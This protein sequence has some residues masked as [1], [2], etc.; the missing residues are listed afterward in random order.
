MNKWA[1]RLRKLRQHPRRGRFILGRLLWRSGLSPFFVSEMPRGFRIRFYPSSISAALW[2]DPGSR[3]EDEDFVW[4]VLRPGDR[5]IDAGANVGQLV[6]A[7]SKRVGPDGDVIAVEAH[8]EI[9]GYLQGNLRLNR[10]SNVEAFNCALGATEG[11]VSMT[12]R[13]SDDQNYV[14]EAGALRVPMHRLD[15]LIPARPTRLLKIDVE[16]SELPVLQGATAV[17]RETELVY[18]ELSTGNCRRFGYEPQDV[19]TLLL[20]AGFVFIRRD[21]EGRPQVSKRAYFSSLPTE[22]LPATGYNLVAVRP[23]VSQEALEMLSARGW[24]RR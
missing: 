11:E 3:T 4:A 24:F 17:L 1:Y 5:Y 19:E 16:G 8:A 23:S 20:E 21:D 18:C 2:A 13:R 12:S 7:A 15:D 10:A 22:D 6:L 14:S 9:Y